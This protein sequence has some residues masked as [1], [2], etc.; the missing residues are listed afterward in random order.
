MAHTRTVSEAETVPANP[1]DRLLHAGLG[2]ITQGLSPSAISLAAADWWLHLA[3]HPGKQAELGYKAWRKWQ[4]LG[5]YNTRCL[6]AGEPVEPCIEPLAGDDRFDDERWH[7]LPWAPLYQSFLLSQQWWY[8]ATTGVRGVDPHHEEVVGFLTRQCLDVASPS[9][10]LPTNPVILARTV[11]EAGYNLL[12]GAQNLLEDQQR[13]LTGEPP[14]GTEAFKVGRDMALTPGQV[15]Y[16]NRLIELIQYEPA[17]RSVHSEPVLIT[18]AWIMKYYILDLRPGK[19]LVEHLVSEG[20][21][22]FMISWRNPTSEDRDLGLD[23]YRRSGVMAALDV[24]ERICP[25]RG[26][27]TV[28]YCLGGTLLMLAGATMARDGDDRIASMTLLAAQSDF[29]EPGELELFIDES[30]VAFLEDVMWARGYLSQGHMAG[31]FQLLRSQDLIW[32]RMVTHYLLGERE[33]TIDL[34]AWNADATRLPYRMHSEYLRDLFMHN[35]FVEGRY[36]VDGQ[37]IHLGDIK[38]PMFVVGTE[39]DHIAPW[40]SVYKIVRLARTPVTFL[41][42]SGGHNAGIVTPPGHPRRSYRLI[43][44]E[45]LDPYLPPDQFLAK[46]EQAQGSWWPAWTAWLNDHS[47]GT[48]EPPSM[49][50]PDHELPALE[51]APGS[52]VLM[53]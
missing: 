29:T 33:D 30:Q 5:L 13:K 16:R 42:T 12:R 14:A 17:T 38:A 10:F 19:S 52:Y 24:V 49:G 44:H 26:I 18:P 1:L 32:S 3:L 20:Y 15:V 48:V 25:G 39:K 53:R 8:N 40:R 35:D 27:H 46:A 2:E 51:P 37:P 50:A 4:R 11:D 9:N 21:T 28:G 43:D 34:M 7:Q 41:L 22:V 47:G 36:D 31:A 45:P 23:D 6:L